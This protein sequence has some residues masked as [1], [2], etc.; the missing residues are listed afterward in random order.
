MITAVLARTSNADLAIATFVVVEAAGWFITAPVGQLQS[1]AIVLV[2][3]DRAHR[4]VRGFAA[5]LALGVTLILAVLVLPPLRED[6][7][8]TLMYRRYVAP[9]LRQ[10]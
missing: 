1:A 4:R 8:R 7:Y 3:G 5:A 2:D 6:V 10:G 9:P